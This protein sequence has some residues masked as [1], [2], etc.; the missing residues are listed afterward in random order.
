M[1]GRVP[2]T[3]WWVSRVRSSHLAP[4]RR[5]SRPGCTST[6]IYATRP[7]RVPKPILLL[8]ATSGKTLE[9]IVKEI[10]VEKGSNLALSKRDGCERCEDRLCGERED[11]ED[12]PDQHYYQQGQ[13]PAGAVGG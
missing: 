6:P 13:P 9:V 11:L 8:E 7:L 2:R 1:H 4:H 3:S 5:T 12:H 10:S